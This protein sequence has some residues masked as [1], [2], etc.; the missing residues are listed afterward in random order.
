MDGQRH[1]SSRRRRSK[2]SRSEDQTSTHNQ[3]QAPLLQFSGQ[4]QSGQQNSSPHRSQQSGQSRGHNGSPSAN[5]NRAPNGGNRRGSGRGQAPR[6]EPILIAA[7]RPNAPA[8]RP[9]RRFIAASAAPKQNGSIPNDYDRPLSDESSP[10]TE[11]S[12][13]RDGLGKRHH[14]SAGASANDDT[15]KPR[16]ARIVQMQASG[17]DDREKQRLKLIDRL[18]RSEGRVAITR[19]A[20]ELEAAGFEFPVEQA[21]QLQLLEHFDESCAHQAICNLTQL[22][23]EEAP[24]KRPLFEQ[25]LRRLEEFADDAETRQAAADLR[26]VVRA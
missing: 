14:Q 23:N 17:P 20:R 24:I 22:L 4:S 2:R 8:A 18:L 25:R 1:S 21:V 9:K 11:S 15:A 7:R 12:A 3:G 19:A 10:D 16:S 13:R 5:Q 6:E 26:R